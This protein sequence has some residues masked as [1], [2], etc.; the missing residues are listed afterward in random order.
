MAAQAYWE[1]SKKLL[2]VPYVPGSSDST[3]PLLDF[4][5]PI[6]SLEERQ[7]LLFFRATCLPIMY[8]YP[9]HTRISTGKV[10]LR[11]GSAD[12]IR[13]ALLGKTL[14]LRYVSA[15][16]YR[17]HCQGSF[18]CRETHIVRAALCLLL[19]PGYY[20]RQRACVQV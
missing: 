2:I 6:L 17:R 12:G 1:I 8:V 4:E 16:R 9:N 18:C 5:Q 14:C 3:K 13:N 20:C 11:P 10:R 7:T 15:P 19:G